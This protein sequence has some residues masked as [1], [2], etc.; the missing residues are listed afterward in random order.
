[1]KT[2]NELFNFCLPDFV[3]F[4]YVPSKDEKS[5]IGCVY[6]SNSANNRNQLRL[7]N[8]Y[9]QPYDDSA[10]MKHRELKWTV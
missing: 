1:M 10:K 6:C 2:T 7:L 4:F 9:L 8:C 5:T 3:Q